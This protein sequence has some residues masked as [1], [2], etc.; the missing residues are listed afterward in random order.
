MLL[1]LLLLIPL[2]VGGGAFYFYQTRISWKE[3][4]F[5]EATSFATIGLLFLLAQWGSLQDVEHWN[6]RITEKDQGTEPCCHCRSVCDSRDSKGN[7]TSSHTECDHFQDYWWKLELST[8]DEVNDGCNSSSWPPQWWSA[9]YIGEPASAEHTYQ[10]YLR[11]DPDSLLVHR[12]AHKQY[13]DKIPDEPPALYD[14]YKVD[15]VYAQGV[16][17]PP[18]WERDLRTINADLGRVRQVDLMVYATSVGDPAFA[19][20]VEEKWL[21]GPKN[22]IIVV[23]G[24]ENNA[25]ISWARVVTLSK[26]EAL[27]IEI[28]DTLEGKRINDPSIMPFLRDV[29]ERKFRRTPMEEFSYLASAAT[30]RGWWLALLFAGAFAVSIGLTILVH[31]KDLFN[32]GG[33]ETRRFRP[34]RF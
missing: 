24:I 7:C 4:L 22:A 13:L 17:L 20:A 6:G 14:H 5:Q 27:K 19:D 10:N 9:A 23:L 21:Y 12:T 33:Q 8:G 15:K 3:F 34:R 25:I 2:L 18:N 28:R 11:A 32:E 31:Q 1:L 16:W 30:P 26:V 29:V